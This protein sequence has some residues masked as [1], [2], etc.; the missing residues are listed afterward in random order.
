MIL[1]TGKSDVHPAGVKNRG[2][3]STVALIP[4][5]RV[6]PASPISPGNPIHLAL[7]TFGRAERD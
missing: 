6:S 7:I 3:L 5:E 4:A 1:V 2:R